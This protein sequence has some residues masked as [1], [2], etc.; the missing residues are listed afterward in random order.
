MTEPH[1]AGVTPP[2]RF[3]G[4]DVRAEVAAPTT[5]KGQ[6]VQP[7][8]LPLEILEALFV[9]PEGELVRE[10]S[11][12]RWAIR[13]LHRAPRW[14][15]RR[16]DGRWRRL[17]RPPVQVQA[18]TVA[19]WA[20]RPEEQV[21]HLRW[22]APVVPRVIVTPSADV[23]LDAIEIAQIE[24]TGVGIAESGD[25]WWTV[26]PPPTDRIRLTAHRWR[27]A[28]VA[29][30]EFRKSAEARRATPSPS[31]RDRSSRRSR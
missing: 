23:A 9:L 18:V 30:D 3:G 8:D 15:A 17:F 20:M 28:L 22:L 21:D 24:G 4:V 6:E 26:V 10:D 13:E 16:S 14:A 25:G 31:G 7:S 12:P 1:A 5:W 2:F 29:A 19:D 11:L 27:L